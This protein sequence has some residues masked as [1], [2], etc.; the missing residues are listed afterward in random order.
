MTA[1][2]CQ[3]V[4]DLIV[5]VPLKALLRGTPF[6]MTGV[7]KTGASFADN[8]LFTAADADSIGTEAYQ[9]QGSTEILVED[10]A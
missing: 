4:M 8:K 1:D 10:G 2:T 9:N 5:A 6:F 7:D 3:E